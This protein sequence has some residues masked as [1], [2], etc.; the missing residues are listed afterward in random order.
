MGSG[1][2]FG[3]VHP[4]YNKGLAD[5]RAITEVPMPEKLV[6]FFGQNLGAPSQPVV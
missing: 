3:G 2:F 1:K 5:S 4:T 6:V